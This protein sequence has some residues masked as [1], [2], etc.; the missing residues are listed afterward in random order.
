L[1]TALSAA[2]V[3]WPSRTAH[4]QP[5]SSPNIFHRTLASSNVA[6]A[7]PAALIFHG[8]P[9]MTS[10]TAYLIFW[11]PPGTHFSSP[12]SDANYEQ[13]IEQ[14]FQDVGGS[15][16][17][18][19]ATQ[20]PGSNGTPVNA[21]TLGGSVLDTN[22]YPHAGTKADPLLDADIV[23]E[24]SSVILA[25]SWPTGLGTMY[26]VF[27]GSGIESCFDATHTF[28][29]P[30]QYC[31]YHSYFTLNS[32]FVVFGNMA[33]RYSTC[34]PIPIDI[35]GDPAADTEVSLISH[36]HLEAVTDPLLNAWFDGGGLEVADKCQF[37]FGFGDATTPNVMLN[38]HPYRLQPEW[39]NVSNQCAFG[40]SCP[41]SPA[42]NC[43]MA[44]RSSLLL[45]SPLD[46]TK[47]ALKWTWSK[48]AA[49]SIQEFGDPTTTTSYALCIYDGGDLVL[50][51]EV[52]DGELCGGEPC[53]SLVS[54][55]Y[56]FKNRA[57]LFSGLTG[58]A[59]KANAAAPKSK[60]TFKGKGGNL[61]M[62]ALGL[63]GGPVTVQ[64]I[65]DTSAVCFEGSYSGTDISANETIKFK[66]T[67]RQ[68]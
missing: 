68:P 52:P 65:D 56:K 48:G 36:E 40:L 55:G 25:Q 45:K 32:D 23:N 63:S 51:V 16:L 50:D 46:V 35:T 17:Y 26:F 5:L 21:V 20:Y 29:T 37:T 8:G 47:H 64:L 34:L 6:A 49:T 67:H 54:T 44:G 62:P 19:I 43:R 12:I 31:A 30:N 66:A 15:T 3:T 10:F 24:I 22:P 1:A 33:D 53:W 59:L 9:V 14:Y 39:S 28:C 18:N 13:V 4:A 7:S 58:I 11:L 27:T 38:G 61:P 2:G 57:G 41:L 60:I 42:A